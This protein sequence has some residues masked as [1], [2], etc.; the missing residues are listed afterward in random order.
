MAVQQGTPQDDVLVGNSADDPNVVYGLGGN[1]RLYGTG[2]VDSLYGGDGNDRLDGRGADY[3]GFTLNDYL[4]GGRGDDLYFVRE[5]Q[6]YI[7]ELDDEGVDSVLSF[8]LYYS[9]G[10]NI[11]NL[12]LAG[13]ARWGYGNDLD[14]IINGNSSE[15]YI[16]A[17]GGAD[18]FSGADGADLIRGGTGNDWIRGGTGADF[19]AGEEGADKFAYYT[20]TESLVGDRDIITD[21]TGLASGTPAS[22]RDRIDLH[23]IDAD[24]STA[25][26]DAFRFLGTAAFTG[27]AG[28]LRIVA[29]TLEVV[30]PNPDWFWPTEPIVYTTAGYIVEGDVTGDGMADFQLAVATGGVLLAGDF[31]L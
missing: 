2:G 29:E 23:R 13:G 6:D 22:E 21:F 17:G 27:R 18:A 30:D 16:A 7:Y 31:S 20:V 12:S 8:S 26:D 28:E 4:E 15:N 24:S 3:G 14:N 25:A 5:N 19:L 10:G 1:D 11:E 9:L